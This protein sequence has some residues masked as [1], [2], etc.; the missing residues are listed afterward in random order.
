MIMDLGACQGTWAGTLAGEYTNSFQI[1]V[2]N[3]GS[4]TVGSGFTAPYSGKLFC[5]SGDATGILIQTQAIL[6]QSRRWSFIKSIGY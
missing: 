3:T 5:E 2:D 1:T 4:I 6:C